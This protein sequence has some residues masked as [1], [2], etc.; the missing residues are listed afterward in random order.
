MARCLH[1]RSPVLQPIVCTLQEVLVTPSSPLS[2][3][4]Q[5]YKIATGTHIVSRQPHNRACQLQPIGE[6]KL[7]GLS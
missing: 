7:P 2:N 6:V 5:P 3:Q 4:K 1:I